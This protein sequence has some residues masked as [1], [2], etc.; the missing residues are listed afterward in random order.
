MVEIIASLL[1]SLKGQS[2]EYKQD[3]DF[4]LRIDSL[5]PSI[6]SIESGYIIGIIENATLDNGNETE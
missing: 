3:V 1:N 4:N 6:K 2:E 5:F